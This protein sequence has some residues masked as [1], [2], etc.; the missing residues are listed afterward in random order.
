M[1]IETLPDQR[2]RFDLPDAVTYLNCAYMAPQLRSVTEAGHAAVARKAQPWHIH[3]SDFFDDVER[4]RDRFATLVGGDA[5]GVAV[6]P[7]VS[8]GISTAAAQLTPEDGS[9]IVVLAE[10]FPSN[11]YPWRELASGTGARLRTIRRPPDDDWTP[12]LLAAIGDR[13]AV[14]AV[15]V[16]HWTDGTVVDL[17]RVRAAARDVGAAVVVDGTQAVGA[18]PID[19]GALEPDFLVAAAYKW[20]LGPYSIGL[21]WVHPSRRSG[22]PIEHGW[23]ARAGSENF[24]GLV[25][26]RDDYRPGARR[27]DVGETANFVLVPMTLAAIDQLLAWGVD[28]VAATCRVLTDAI[29]DAASELGVG[30]PSPTVRSA[31]LI[32]LTLPAHMQARDVS[33]RLQAE[34][35]HVSLR[36]RSIRVS[37]H[38][39]NDLGDVRHLAEVL[40]AASMSSSTG[41]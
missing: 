6:V 36:G 17:A 23:V 37:P 16:C 34:S 20:L 5:D 33:A 28:R 35:V 1:S 7:S 29:A 8:Y 11:V 24:A 26:Y 25:D 39:Y 14:V 32:G 18:V 22:R 19:V 9:E 38:V 30:T 15:P 41:N 4:L 27:Y 12:A 40:R 10:Q 13:T 21:M 2:D 31:H 3:T